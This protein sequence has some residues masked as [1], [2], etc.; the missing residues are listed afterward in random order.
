MST[1]LIEAVPSSRARAEPFPIPLQAFLISN[2]HHQCRLL[3]SNP[4][5]YPTKWIGGGVDLLERWRIFL[6]TNLQLRGPAPIHLAS[7]VEGPLSESKE[8]IAP[9]PSLEPK[10]G[11]SPP[12][13]ASK[14][15]PS[16]SMHW[17]Q[18][19]VDSPH[20]VRRTKARLRP[21]I[22]PEMMTICVLL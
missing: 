15:L 21:L 19:K 12:L 17:R 13:L 22:P 20:H 10:V 7:L 1:Q 5:R 16:S 3:G 14:N 2:M 18:K 9:T 8:N 4:R 11:E 6:R